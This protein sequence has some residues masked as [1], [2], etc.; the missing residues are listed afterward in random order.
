ML[1]HLSR[2]AIFFFKNNLND[3]YAVLIHVS[4]F[5]FSFKPYQ[6]HRLLG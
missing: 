6:F 3:L 1:F 4:V 5:C 2:F